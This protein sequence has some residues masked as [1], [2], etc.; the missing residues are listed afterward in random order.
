VKAKVL[1]AIVLTQLILL[2]STAWAEESSEPRPRI[3][4]IGGDDR[5]PGVVLVVIATVLLIGFGIGL[6]VGRRTRSK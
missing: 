5:S 1:S 6:T 4:N 3:S 2:S